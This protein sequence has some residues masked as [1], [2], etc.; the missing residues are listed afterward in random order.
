MQAHLE[1]IAWLNLHRLLTS[2]TALVGGGWGASGTRIWKARPLEVS[3]ALTSQ[4]PPIM[5]FDSVYLVCR[6]FFPPQSLHG[7]SGEH[8]VA[9]ARVV[10]NAAFARW[11]KELKDQVQEHNDLKNFIHAAF[12]R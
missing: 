9:V 3:A 10:N 6:E 2:C 12:G 5:K 7:H 11:I 4:W 1:R 8:Y